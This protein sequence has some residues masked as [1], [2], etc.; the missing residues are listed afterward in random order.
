[1]KEEHII[2]MEEEISSLENFKEIC[3]FEDEEKD[4]KIFI[5]VAK[6]KSQILKQDILDRY[7]NEE[8]W[9]EDLE[10]CYEDIEV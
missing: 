1:M 9:D 8:Y 2:L 5:Q 7:N 3:I 10:N 4:I 6:S